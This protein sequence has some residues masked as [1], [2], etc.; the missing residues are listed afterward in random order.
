VFNEDGE[1]EQDHVACHGVRENMPVP[2]IRETIQE[3]AGGG[4]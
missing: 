2:R 3:A 4:W 1:Q